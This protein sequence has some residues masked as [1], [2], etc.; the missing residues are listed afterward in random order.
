MPTFSFLMALWRCCQFLNWSGQCS[1]WRSPENDSKKQQG[2]P[3]TTVPKLSSATVLR[4]R[5]DVCS[6]GAAPHSPLKPCPVSESLQNSGSLSP[7]LKTTPPGTYRP[8]KERLWYCQVPSPHL[9]SEN[10]MAAPRTAASALRN[11]ASPWE[12]IAVESVAYSACEHQSHRSS[13]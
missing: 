12:V 3:E 9:L 6:G 1:I 7:V 10:T 13:V 2:L 11:P 5:S 4:P 8:H